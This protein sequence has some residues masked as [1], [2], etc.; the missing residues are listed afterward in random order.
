[1]D[2]KEMKVL[3]VVLP[4][5]GLMTYLRKAFPIPLMGVGDSF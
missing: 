1:M 3:E 5:T 2:L 4:G